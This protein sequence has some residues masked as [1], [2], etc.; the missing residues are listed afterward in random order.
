MCVRL[1]RLLQLQS[2]VELCAIVALGALDYYAFF[3]PHDAPMPITVPLSAATLT[4]S[5]LGRR[6]LSLA[7]CRAECR[8]ERSR[9]DAQ[10]EAENV[11][12]AENQMAVDALW[13]VRDAVHEWPFML[14]VKRA[15]DRAFMGDVLARFANEFKVKADGSI[16]GEHLLWSPFK[17]SSEQQERLVGKTTMS[18]APLTIEDFE[19]ARGGDFKSAARILRVMSFSHYLELRSPSGAGSNGDG[20][21]TWFAPN[22]VCPLP[23]GEPS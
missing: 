14:G 23:Q 7:V 19:A 1:H 17:L 9:Y 22:A 20:Y 10:R 21:R 2:V 5:V 8:R 6:V 18:G 4:L 12:Q 16:D 11:R 15:E 13:A 3:A